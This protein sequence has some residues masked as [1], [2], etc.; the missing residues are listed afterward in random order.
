[1]SKFHYDRLGPWRWSYLVEPQHI[2]QHS[3]RFPVIDPSAMAIRPHPRA[4]RCC[5]RS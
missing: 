3:R 4:T 5:Q 1:M 2:Q